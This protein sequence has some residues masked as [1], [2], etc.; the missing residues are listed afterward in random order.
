M[1]E[2]RFGVV[3]KWV[4]ILLVGFCAMASVVFAAPVVSNPAFSVS[5]LTGTEEYSYTSY[6]GL[7]LDGNTLYFGNYD[8]VR[9][10]NLS[11]STEGEFAECGSN[12]GSSTINKFSG[13]FYMSMDTSYS[14]PYPSNFGTIDPANGFQATITSGTTIGST[15]YSIFDSVVYGG[16]LYFVSNMGT[17]V[18]NG[19]G[20]KIGENFGT[21]IF[22]YNVSEPTNP[23]LIATIGG[24]SGGLTFDTAGNMYYASQNSGE[25]ILMFTAAEVAAG[26]LTAADGTTVVNVASASIGFLSD[27]TLLAETGYGQLL[28]AYD[29]E[30]GEKVY[31]IATTSG[32]DYMGKFVIGGDDTIYILSND[33]NT[34]YGDTGDGAVL[35]AI[36]VPEPVTMTL[37]VSGG[38]LL[39]L[40]KRRK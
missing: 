6:G 32:G 36:N 30:T 21:S 4:I 17:Y 2:E 20:G 12:S 7:T 9:T 10:Y 34:I 1:R 40:K 35:S 5:T 3:M 24:S 25:G 16:N 39:F 37:L 31:N 27:G 28:A 11:T 13:G 19:S 8:Y 18:D 15:T 22:C 14:S 29:I 26:N 23:T 33:W 38:V